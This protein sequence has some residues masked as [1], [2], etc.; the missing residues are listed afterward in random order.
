VS[1]QAR[2]EAA[3]KRAIARVVTEVADY[4]GNTPAVARASY[5]DP[6]VIR[7]YENGPTV[8]VVLG[9]LG[10]LGRDSGF[11]DLPPGA[12]PKAPS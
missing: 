6:R 12:A 10:D 9:D 4:L 7:H 8:A 1:G 3:R 5:I 11:G 2:S